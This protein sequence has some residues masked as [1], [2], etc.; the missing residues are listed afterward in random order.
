LQ[1]V[2]KLGVCRAAQHE[3]STRIRE[4]RR[5]QRING[6]V[7]RLEPLE[8]SRAQPEVPLTEDGISLPERRSLGKLRREMGVDAAGK[9]V[10][11]NAVPTVARIGR[12]DRPGRIGELGGRR[13]RE[14]G[15][16]AVT[17]RRSLRHNSGENEER[18]R[19][20]AYRNALHVR[21][22]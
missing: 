20:G 14:D 10:E 1:R 9:E 19:Q 21:V 13:A 11:E 12:L 5:I 3:A 7:A 22:R 4:S 6:A 16:V 8:G 18:R 15:L 17:Q 2:E